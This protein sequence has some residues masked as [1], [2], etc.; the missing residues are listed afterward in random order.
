MSEFLA[1]T[2]A[3]PNILDFAMHFAY[4]S[5]GRNDTQLDAGLHDAKLGAPCRAWL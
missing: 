4:H 3:N 5:S 2:A 1:W